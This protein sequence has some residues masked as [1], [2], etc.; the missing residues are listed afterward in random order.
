MLDGSKRF[1]LSLHQLEILP[2]HI[3]PTEETFKYHLLVGAQ[4]RSQ[5][6]FA[7][8]IATQ[9]LQ[10]LVMLLDGDSNVE[11]QSKKLWE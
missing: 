5:P 4:I 7:A 2:L 1:S 6:G 9:A 3:A 10:E 11:R 8:T